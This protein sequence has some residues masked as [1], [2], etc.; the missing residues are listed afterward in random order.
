MQNENHIINK[1]VFE[2]SCSRYEDAFQLQKQMES[3]LQHNIQA[4][5]NKALCEWNDSAEVV[6]IDKLEIDIGDIPFDNLAGL[7]PRKIYTSLAGRFTTTFVP[8]KTS[9][10]AIE[11]VQKNSDTDTIEL[12]EI[13]LLSGSLP[14]WA[15]EAGSFSLTET[16]QRVIEND[17]GNL[18]SLL[19][20]YILNEKFT[21]RLVHQTDAALL[22]KLTALVPEMQSLH[23]IIEDLIIKLFIHDKDEA[24]PAV[25]NTA[26]TEAENQ[27]RI[28]ASKNIFQLVLKLIATRPLP[29][30][31]EQFKL[32]LKEKI[33]EVF[34]KMIS[35]NRFDEIIDLPLAEQSFSLIK[36]YEKDIEQTAHEENFS[37]DEKTL[38]AS[39]EKIY[40]QN[41]G[42]VLIA[43]FF[44]A[45]FTK[46][47]WTVDGVFSNREMQLKALF[48]LHYITTG[49][50]AS[51]EYT[52]QLNKILCGFKLDEPIPFSVE[53]T[54]EEKQEA[55]QLLQDAIG[56]WAALK[57]SNI[58]SLRGSFLLRDALLSYSNG[59][60][61]LQVERKGYDVL[62]DH[63]PWSWETVKF[64]WM[65]SYLETEW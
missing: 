65:E 3:G 17:T 31:V 38:A 6:R 26:V 2:F 33:D 64:G 52:L 23:S 37:F 28:N 51:P 56:H 47:Q 35:R 13:F 60:W 1:Q 12:L 5:I 54:T 44:P 19:L 11:T 25:N 29:A 50:D 24:L 8:G 63:I 20:K 40:I 30:N 46:L 58:E 10:A 16:I 55:D 9:I 39:G 62:L 4:C 7:L 15:G 45:L 49:I 21:E 43:T 22:Q 36:T 34:G 42:L 18:K 59:R 27:Q 32:L 61:L 48:L 14:W 57:G 41:A 53:L